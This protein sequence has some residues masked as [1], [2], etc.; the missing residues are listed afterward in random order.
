MSGQP[1]VASLAPNPAKVPETVFIVSDSFIYT[2]YS[3]TKYYAG[4]CV[5][6][7]CNSYNIHLPQVFVALPRL[8]K[9]LFGWRVC[10]SRLGHVTFDHHF[11]A[12]FRERHVPW[13]SRSHRSPTSASWFHPKSRTLSQRIG[14]NLLSFPIH[15]VVYQ[16]VLLIL[17]STSLYEYWQACSCLVVYFGFHFRILGCIGGHD[18]IQLLGEVLDRYCQALF[19][20]KRHQVSA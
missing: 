5:G 13:Q 17:L 9:V 15:L 10:S 11:M 1:G 3:L 20:A 19:R 7:V 18:R 2:K 12:D 8:P 16:A 14:C 4:C 6:R